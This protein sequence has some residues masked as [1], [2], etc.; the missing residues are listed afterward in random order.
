MSK[1]YSPW[2]QSV[3]LTLADTNYNLLTLLQAIDSEVPAHV[4][5]IS[6]QV[7]IDEAAARVFVGNPDTLTATNQGAVLVATME[8]STGSHESNLI[9]LADIELRSDAANVR[10]NVSFIVR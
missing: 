6:I 9:Y 5:S 1:P 4:Q 2:L 7:D 10:L 3:T 8:W